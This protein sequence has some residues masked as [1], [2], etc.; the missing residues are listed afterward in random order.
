V[1]LTPNKSRLPQAVIPQRLEPKNYDIFR[2]L[3]LRTQQH[4]TFAESNGKIVIDQKT[5]KQLL[6]L[7]GGC[8]NELIASRFRGCD[9]FFTSF[10]MHSRIV[11]INFWIGAYS[12]E[13]ARGN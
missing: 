9:N 6:V 8:T 13:S 3:S 10:S 5:F 4:L 7:L 1:R 12:Q 2:R 11:Q